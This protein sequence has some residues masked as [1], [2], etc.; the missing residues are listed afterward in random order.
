MP[1]RTGQAHE[2]L[3]ASLQ[4]DGSNADN[5]PDVLAMCMPSLLC[6][7]DQ[8]PIRITGNHKFTYTDWCL[9]DK[10]QNHDNVVLSSGVC[11]P[12][13]C[14]ARMLQDVPEEPVLILE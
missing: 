1:V 3:R 12:D 13:A 5:I 2:G 4:Q 9:L 14:Y 10:L 7:G 8:D 6:G 11:I